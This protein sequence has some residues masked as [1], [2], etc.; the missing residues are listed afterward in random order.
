MKDFKVVHYK[1]YQCMPNSIYRNYGSNV[2]DLREAPPLVYVPAPMARLPHDVNHSP[3]D[4][5][6]PR[7]FVPLVS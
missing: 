7:L 6:V 1:D 4:E 3:D 2:P 5:P